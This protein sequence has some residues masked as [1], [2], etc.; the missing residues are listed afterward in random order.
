MI[1]F[2]W[3]YLRLA[4]RVYLTIIQ[5]DS[6]LSYQMPSRF[7]LEINTLH[8]WPGAYVC[9]LNCLCECDFSIPIILNSL[10]S[11]GFN[12]ITYPPSYRS[13]RFNQLNTKN[14][15]EPGKTKRRFWAKFH[16]FS[17]HFPPIFRLWYRIRRF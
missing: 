15:S 12:F 16:L 17:A 7:C 14:I 13:H 4:E 3:S 9:S 11:E 10:A 6:S 8:C 1:M 5:K 2:A